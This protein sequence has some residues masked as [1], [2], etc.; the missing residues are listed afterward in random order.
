MKIMQLQSTLRT[1]DHRDHLPGP[2][3]PSLH[4]A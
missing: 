3:G 1:S 2:Y 4:T